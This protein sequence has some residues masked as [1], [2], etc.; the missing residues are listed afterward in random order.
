MALAAEKKQVEAEKT[1]ARERTA[2]DQKEID[3]L[4]LERKQVLMEFSSLAGY[5]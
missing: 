1:K 3:G 4:L 2:V 5:F